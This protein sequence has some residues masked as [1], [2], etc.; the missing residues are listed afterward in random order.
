L[1]GL[2]LVH[3]HQRENA[4]GGHGEVADLFRYVLVGNP[5]AVEAH[6][7]SRTLGIRL[8]NHMLDSRKTQ[9]FPPGSYLDTLYRRFL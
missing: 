4:L 5:E 2:R 9:P 7:T 6:F 8:W 3:L 1:S